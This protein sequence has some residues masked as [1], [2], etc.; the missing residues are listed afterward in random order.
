ME[1]KISC[2]SIWVS[3]IHHHIY[4]TIWACAYLPPSSSLAD[5]WAKYSESAL[6]TDFFF[7]DGI[8]YLAIYLPFQL[9]A[10]GRSSICLLCL[11]PFERTRL[12]S[13]AGW[14]PFLPCAPSALDGEIFLLPIFNVG[15]PILS[16][17]VDHFKKGSPG[18]YRFRRDKHRSQSL[19][20]WVPSIPYIDANM[21]MQTK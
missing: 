15:G 21:T 19:E 5:S 3:F 13:G 9:L 20:I 16:L 4:T 8:L 1:F 2:P 10:N 6:S 12:K 7:T 11:S 18:N 14:H 17:G